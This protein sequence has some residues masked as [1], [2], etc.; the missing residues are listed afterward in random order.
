MNVAVL[1]GDQIK[2]ID[3]QASSL[4][5]LSGTPD[6]APCST[7]NRVDGRR[8]RARPAG[9]VDARAGRGGSLVV[10]ADREEWRESIVHP[11]SYS[12]TPAFAELADSSGRRLGKRPSPLAG[13]P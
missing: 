12:V 11:I 9:R 7:H 1:E 8:Q 13:T 2:V 10:P 5:E 6:L 4:P 3:E